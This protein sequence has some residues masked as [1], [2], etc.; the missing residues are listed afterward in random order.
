MKP[1]ATRPIQADFFDERSNTVVTWLGMAGA[2][3]NVRGTILLI[4]PLLTMSVSDGRD[5]CEG[6]HP[7]K[8]PLPIEAKDLPRLDAV[9]YTHADF[10]HF[11][12]LTAQVLADR[13]DPRF[14]APGPVVAQLRDLGVAE[15]RITQ[16][17]EDDAFQLGAAMILVT[18]ALHDWQEQDPWQLSDCCGYLIRTPDGSIWHPGDTRLIPAL[19]EIKEVDL[20]FFDVADV[21]AHLGPQGSAQLAESCGAKVMLAYHYGTFDLPPGSYGS[22]DPDDS[23]VYIEHLD[24]EFMKPD[25]G[26]VLYLPIDR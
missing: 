20:F 6:E 18:P 22:C 19:L 10:D 15:E 7:L 5:L 8:L 12:P 24:A 13:F 17:R 2:L 1:L 11:G 9:L 4:D 16:V 23:L 21:D 25:P 14:I 26:E 3:I